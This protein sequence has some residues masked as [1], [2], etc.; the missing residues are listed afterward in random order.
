MHVRR[1]EDESYFI[2]EGTINFQLGDDK[3]RATPG[4]FIQIPQGPCG[5]HPIRSQTL[6]EEAIQHRFENPKLLATALVHKS[7]LHAV[8]DSSMSPKDRLESLSD[9]VLRLLASHD[10]FVAYPSVREDQL[11]ALRR[12]LFR[13][14]TLVENAAPIELGEYKYVSIGE[15]AAGGRTRPS[16]LGRALEALL[17]AVYLDGGL[18]VV[19]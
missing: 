19:R 1:N 17:G 3:T 18:E 4:T 2:L 11:S 15:E 9:A 8:P 13:L 14:N 6:L 5:A 7:Y 12:A 16:N 10:L